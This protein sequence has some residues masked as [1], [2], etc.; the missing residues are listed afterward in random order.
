MYLLQGLPEGRAGT[1]NWVLRISISTAASRSP[2]KTS[3]FDVN[4]LFQIV[5]FKV[6][7]S[8]AKQACAWA[9]SGKEDVLA[10]QL[11]QAMML[12]SSRC[13]LPCWNCKSCHDLCKSMIPL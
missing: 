7:Q 5:C 12:E 2:S 13:V 6:M 3:R 1:R 9:M 11:L 4:W 8:Y 10:S